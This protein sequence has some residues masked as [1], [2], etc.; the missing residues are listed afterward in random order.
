MLPLKCLS[1]SKQRDPLTHTTWDETWYEDPTGQHGM[2]ISLVTKANILRTCN[3]AVTYYPM[4]TKL[5]P[6]TSAN[7]SVTKHL[8]KS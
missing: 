5:H 6:T 8:T 3:T 1:P 4:Y 2:K 7:S